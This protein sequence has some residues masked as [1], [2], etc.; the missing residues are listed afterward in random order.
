MSD[1][2]KSKG[3]HKKLYDCT[4]NSGV[5]CDKKEKC[6]GCGWR[7]AVSERRCDA[8]RAQRAQMLAEGETC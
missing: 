7:P 8:I 4:Y 5:Q 2:V 6:I 1:E 3:H